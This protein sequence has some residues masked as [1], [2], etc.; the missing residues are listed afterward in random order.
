MLAIA[1]TAAMLTPDGEQF[2]FPLVLRVVIAS[3]GLIVP[4]IA[5]GLAEIL[6]VQRPGGR[7]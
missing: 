6:N 2:K 5:W 4:A 7:D 3:V 1:V